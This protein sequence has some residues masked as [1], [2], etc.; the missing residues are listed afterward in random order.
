[1]NII[2]NSTNKT[3][4]MIVFKPNK[5]GF[6]EVTSNLKSTFSALEGLINWLRREW[7]WK[8]SYFFNALFDQSKIVVFLFVGNGK[9]QASC[10]T[11]GKA[12]MQQEHDNC[13]TPPPLHVEIMPRRFNSLRAS[14][15]CCSISL[16]AS[17][18]SRKLAT[19]YMTLTTA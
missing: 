12:K 18:Q 1:M 19:P 6:A 10:S 3:S 17:G 5:I 13:S 15:T 16:A 7:T 9:R 2:S 11:S 14:I 8:E 4:T